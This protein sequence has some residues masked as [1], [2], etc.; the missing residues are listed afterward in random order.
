MD[1]H[2]Y[3]TQNNV[4]LLIIKFKNRYIFP[5][6]IL[7]FF[8][9]T[10]KLPLLHTTVYLNNISTVNKHPSFYVQSVQSWLAMK[11]FHNTYHGFIFQPSLHLCEDQLQQQAVLW[12]RPEAVEYIYI[13]E[14]QV[15]V[16]LQR[17]FRG[18]GVTWR[19]Q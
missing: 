9:K 19:K 17:R 4:Y 8:L 13:T 10:N 12:K 3:C 14:H 11:V 1:S 18:Y 7:Y 2:I 5:I 15:S 16:N 6:F